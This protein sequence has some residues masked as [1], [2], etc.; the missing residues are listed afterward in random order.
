MVQIFSCLCIYFV[1]KTAE[2]VL[3]K[4]SLQSLVGPHIKCSI[5]YRPGNFAET[6]VIVTTS[7][8]RNVNDGN[9]YSFLQ[10][11][12]LKIIVFLGQGFDFYKKVEVKNL[13]F[14]NKHLHFTE[15]P[16]HVYNGQNISK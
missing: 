14:C 7:F 15:C 12:S 6:I 2:I 5:S 9:D 4:H 8:M 3:E 1:Q 16:N 11:F 13:V 10:H